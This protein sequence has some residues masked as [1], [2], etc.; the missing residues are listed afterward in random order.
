[1]GASLDAY[2]QVWSWPRQTMGVSLLCK[3]RGNANEPSGTASN[4][5][6]SAPVVRK[7]LTDVLVPLG[8]CASQCHAMLALLS[9]VALLPHAQ[10]GAIE[11]AELERAVIQHLRLHLAAY[12]DARWAPTFHFCI[13]SGM[14]LGKAPLLPSCFC[15]ERVH[16]IAKRFMQDRCRIQSWERGLLEDVTVQHMHHLCDPTTRATMLAPRVASKRVRDVV[17]GLGLET[18]DEEAATS[19]VA[20]VRANNIGHTD[21]AIVNEG[22]A[23][24]IGSVMRHAC[25]RG[26][27]LSVV[28]A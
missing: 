23:M 16:R 2:L 21:V 19:F 14:G 11:P 8:V 3:L 26:R 17:R 5:L 28:S 4:I 10:S 13:A 18:N 24:R 27:T 1:M 9:V 22:H 7:W 25:F 15:M 6:A 20:V 12:G